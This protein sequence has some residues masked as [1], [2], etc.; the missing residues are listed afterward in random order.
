MGFIRKLKTETVDRDQQLFRIIKLC[1]C[2]IRGYIS[3]QEQK[4][5]NELLKANQLGESSYLFDGS[6]YAYRLQSA[7]PYHP[8]TYY[9][10]FL[11]AIKRRKRQRR[12]YQLGGV[13]ALV[14]CILSCLLLLPTDFRD[15]ERK[16]I[17]AQ[18]QIESKAFLITSSREKLYI[19][20]KSERTDQE[21]GVL[22]KQHEGK[23]TYINKNKI[24]ASDQFNELH[25]KRGGMYHLILSDGTKVWLN[26]E[27][28]LKYPVTFSTKKREVFLTGEAYFKVHAKADHPFYI[29]TSGGSIKVLGT[30]FNVR[31]YC[32]EQEVQ[33]TLVKGNVEYY[34]D[35]TLPT[36][37]VLTP[38][39]QLTHTIGSLHVQVRD[40]DLELIT[41][42]K[43]GFYSFKRTPLKEIMNTI[44][45]NYDVVVHF[46]DEELKEIQF[47]GKIPRYEK[48]E[49][50]VEFIELA[51]R[52]IITIENHQL[53]IEKR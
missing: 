34:A 37:I 27:S 21:Q 9:P 45:R 20:R 16:P 3:V 11:Q 17:T 4:E 8:D 1:L 24:I 22:I 12:F 5:L 47:T 29:H 40:V 7:R 49:D 44:E 32:N 52:I 36:K 39:Q 43:D 25:I 35:T 53:F 46:A 15:T 6:H 42:W 51:D 14:I 26:S 41:S 10:A 30:E 28:K 33:T 13:A 38:G 19:D 18:K 2:R 23:I 50:F 48:L 31:N